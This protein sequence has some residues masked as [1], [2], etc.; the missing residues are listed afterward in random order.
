MKQIVTPWKVEGDLDYQRLIKEFGTS[1]ITPELLTRIKKHTKQLHP[2]LKRKIFFSHRDMNWILDQ[3][4][5]GNEFFLYTG[6][7]PSE[8]VHLGHITVWKFTKWLQDKFGVEVYFQMTDDEKFLF[9]ENLTL[10]ETNKLAY[11]NALD[12]IALGFN[13]KKTKIFSNIDYGKTLYRGAVKVAKKLTFSTVK[14]TFGFSESNNVGQI[15]YTAMQAVPCF[16]PSV[17]Q[18]KKIPW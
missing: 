14:A 18:K 9:K 16:L 5:K 10:E 11:E 12:V 13:P 15:F 4:E 7:G 3:Y 2:Y 8:Q 17:Q 6:R 1:E